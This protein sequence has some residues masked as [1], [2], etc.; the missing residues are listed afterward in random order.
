MPQKRRGPQGKGRGNKCTRG[1]GKGAGL[2]IQRKIPVEEPHPPKKLTSNQNRL[3]SY[4][5]MMEKR[6]AA[7]EAN[8]QKQQVEAQ[9]ASSSSLA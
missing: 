7:K 2:P 1:K 3:I 5:D 9:R 8:L 6:A 4:A